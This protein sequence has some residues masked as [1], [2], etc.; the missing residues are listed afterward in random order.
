MHAP[1]PAPTDLV[2][3]AAAGEPGALEA[4]AR[5]W[6]P[7]I[8]RWTLY[9]LGEPGLA[10]DA[11]Q[12]V[13]ANL[14]RGLDS[15]DPERPFAPW[16]RVV[17]RNACHKV[18]EQHQRHGH[19]P[20]VDDQRVDPGPEPGEALDHKRLAARAIAA[21]EALS[22][23]Q[24][25]VLSLCTFEGM[26]AADAGRA[27]GIAPATARVLLHRARKSLRAQLEEA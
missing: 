10:D 27:L 19:E 23:R 9:Q 7:T 25:E 26:S 8:R 2:Q 15:F 21:F 6:W 22:P 24:R 17:V 3:R 1:R 11:A 13:L 14:A 16:L 5:H 20:L 4:L 18:R 12:E